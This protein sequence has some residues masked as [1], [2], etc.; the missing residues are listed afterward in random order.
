M[1]QTR[2]PHIN[3]Q[4]DKLAEQCQ[5][6]GLKIGGSYFVTIKNVAQDEVAGE[7]VLF[8]CE[9]LLSEVHTVFAEGSEP[10][11]NPKDFSVNDA[12]L[13]ETLVR[14]Q[15]TVILAR[16]FATIEPGLINLYWKDFSSPASEDDITPADIA[17]LNIHQ[18]GQTP[19]TAL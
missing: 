10:I 1:N 16:I 13:M 12:D 18:E 17:A 4:H 14:D 11:V 19:T 8:Y 5:K 7:R 6:A 2:G 15:R 3:Y 9:A